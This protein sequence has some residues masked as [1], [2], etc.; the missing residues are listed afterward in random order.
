M[1]IRLDFVTNSSEVAYIIRNRTDT[2]KTLLDFIKELDHLIDK[3]NERNDYPV[4]RE[5][6][7]EDAEGRLWSVGP[8]EEAFLMLSW[9]SDLLGIILAETLGSGSSESFSWHETDL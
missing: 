9:E 1:K 8:N 6:V 5:D 3:Y 4:S 2:T 7:Y